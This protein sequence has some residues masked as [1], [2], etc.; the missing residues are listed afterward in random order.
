MPVNAGSSTTK[1][2]MYSQTVPAVE[3]YS[4]RLKDREA[5]VAA[6]EAIHIRLGN[7]RLVLAMATVAIAWESLRIHALSAAWMVLPLILFVLVA[8]YHSRILRSRDLA[9]R[10]VAFYRGGIA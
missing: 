6:Y 8:A 4:K 3:E 2:L 7:L 1:R 9:A 10:A 5:R